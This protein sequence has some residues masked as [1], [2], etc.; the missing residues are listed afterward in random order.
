MSHAHM[1]CHTSIQEAI[2]AQLLSE[3]EKRGR[4]LELQ[5]R[6]KE[7]VDLLEVVEKEGAMGREALIPHI[8]RL[9]HVTLGAVQSPLGGVYSCRV[10]GFMAA[11]V[12]QEW[13]LGNCNGCMC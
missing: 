4:L 3:E 1:L 8:P 12:L 6:L 11:A 13:S 7:G 9:C 5:R 2:E 10:W